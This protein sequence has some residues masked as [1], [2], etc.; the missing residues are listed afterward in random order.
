MA[1]LVMAFSTIA[2]RIPIL[3]SSSVTWFQRGTTNEVV[4]NGQALGEVTSIIFSGSG[5]VGIPAP[6]TA[7]AVTLE[8]SGAGLT[9]TAVDN[10]KSR[11]FQIE[12][13]PDAPLGSRELRVASPGGVS[14]PL[15]VNVS[16]LPEVREATLVGS[17]EEGAMV[18]LPTALSGVI[19]A[20]TETDRFRFKARAGEKLIFDVQ[21]NRTGSPLDPT[22]VLLDASGKELARSEDAQGLDP[23]LEFTPTADGEFSVT[24]RDQR[25]QGGGD[26]RYRMVMGAVP[27]L[28]FLFPFGGQRGTSVE[29]QLQG[30]NLE[31]A[32]RMNL[33]LAPD[34]PRGRPDIRAHTAQGYSNPQ[35]FEVGDL[36]EFAEVEPNNS[37]DQAN[38][39]SIPVVIN[40]RI[41]EAKDSDYFRFKAPADGK[42]VADV[43]ARR[44][45]SPLDALLTLLDSQGAVIQR[46]DDSSGPD[47]RIEFDAKKDTDYLLALRDL[48]DRGGSRF[49]YRVTVKAADTT[50]DFV[51]RSPA[52]R[53]RIHQ[54]GFTAVRC[55]LERRNGFDGVVR[56]TGDAL[57]PG[58]TAAA[59]VLGSAPNFGWIVLHAAADAPLGANPLKLIA[60]G[61]RSGRALT[62]PVQFSEQGWLTVLP[63][64]SFELDVAQA[65]ALVEQ[66]TNTVLDVTITRREG[67]NGE[68]KVF[69]EDAPKV[70][71]PAVTISSG[72][73]RAKMV[74]AAAYNADSGPRPIMLRGEA[75]VDGTTNIQYALA[76]VPLTVQGIPM[77]LTAMLPGSPFFRT[78]AVRLSAVALPTNTPSAASRTEFVV[79]VDRRGLPGEIAL[80]LENLP[81]GVLAT[82]NPIR[83]EKN[84]ATIEL[85]VSDQAETG[86]EH[87][88]N[89]IGTVT[90]Q[91]RIWRQKTQP[92]TINIVAPEK[93]T[94]STNSVAP[95]PAPAGK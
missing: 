90:H 61:E 60:S 2:Q 1:W 54:G 23:F 25:F 77:F 50:P 18:T 15:V 53:F 39:V 19:G 47:A 59:L 38:A 13:G 33:R 36:P 58:I 55:D 24:L 94:A 62:R 5:I 75:I 71:I 79:K 63:P 65:S 22:L 89:V 66:N 51:V 48:T 16:D 64:A 30:R 11:A 10:A 86:K 43:Q 92:V 42:L 9:A 8:P 49:G 57:P 40:G 27:Y 80:A 82:V 68:V 45:G 74:L 3:E 20:S 56:I 41:G 72:Q 32:D 52:G 46:N 6:R 4:L 84:E 93:T 78:D 26:Y 34:A 31:N 12:I 37:V 35:P 70:S 7:P 73:A 95:P 29:L 21:A 44:F 14:N 69:A 83:A 81:T 91:D 87:S 88:F 67:F 28:D 17:K 85:L 76:P